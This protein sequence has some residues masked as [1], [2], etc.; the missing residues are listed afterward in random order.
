MILAVLVFELVGQVLPPARAAVTLHGATT[1]FSSSTLS[2]TDGRFRFRDLAA[3]TYTLSAFIPGRGEGQQTIDI[4]PSFADADRRVKVTLQVKESAS[5]LEREGTVSIRELAIPDKAR[6]A[7]A[8]AQKKLE[9]RDVDG[10]VERLQAA[11]EMAPNFSAAWNNL[12]TISYQT[13]KYPEAESYF[14][15]GLQSDPESFAPLVNLGGVLLTLGNID[16]A[17]QYNLFAVLARPDDALANS[18]LGMSYFAAGSPDL[19]KKYLLKAKSLDPAHFSHPQLV[20]AEIYLREGDAGGAAA[21]LEDFLA[22]HPDA[23]Q[24]PKIREAAARLRTG[25]RQ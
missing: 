12:G 8:D 19:A 21:E 9:R 20:L 25:S 16:Q 1:P 13:G 4:G 10:A 22:R 14:R 6:R 24:A 5:D 3:G 7:Y 15:R 23:P 17:M 11:L 18:Q 2:G